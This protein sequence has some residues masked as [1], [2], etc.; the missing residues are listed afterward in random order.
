MALAGGS[1]MRLQ[2]RYMTG[3]SLWKFEDL[4]PRCFAYMVGKSVLA[5]GRKPHFL[6]VYTQL[7]SIYAP[8]SPL[9]ELIECPHNM[10]TQVPQSEWG[11]ICNAF[12]NITWGFTLSFAQCS[13][14]LQVSSIQCGEDSTGK[15]YQQARVFKGH[16]WG[17]LLQLSLGSLCLKCFS[18]RIRET[19]NGKLLQESGKSSVTQTEEVAQEKA[20]TRDRLGQEEQ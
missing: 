16:L 12:Y 8:T 7:R 1:L 18:P 17:W 4:I 15:G 19:R 9:V 3:C 5:V 6:T 10:A 20:D 2:W 13:A 11:G 14:G